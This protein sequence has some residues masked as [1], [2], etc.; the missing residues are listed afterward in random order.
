M[1]ADSLKEGGAV[2]RVEALEQEVARLKDEMQTLRRMQVRSA[3]D[4]PVFGDQVSYFPVCA[5]RMLVAEIAPDLG[6]WFWDVQS[7]TLDC[8]ERAHYLL[9]SPAGVLLTC[10]EVY[11]RIHPEDSEQLVARFA[12]LKANSKPR[13]AEFRVVLS[14]GSVRWLHA[15][16][17]GFSG[18]DGRVA[19]IAGVLVDVTKYKEINMA[20]EAANAELRESNHR[21]DLALRNA[22][23]LVYSTDSDLRYTWIY[24]PAGAFL[25][26]RFLGKRLEEIFPPEDVAELI[27]AK[28]T[29]IST[30]KG[31]W[32]EVKIRLGEEDKY[33]DISIEPLRGSDGKVNGLTAAAME[34]T[35]LRR[36]EDEIVQNVTRLEVQRRLLQHR[37]MERIRIAR[38]LHDGPIQE[39]LA[40]GFTLQSALASTGNLETIQIL[41]NMRVELQRLISDL[42]QV[43]NDLRPPTLGSFG[44]EK[45]IRSHAMAFRERHPEIQIHL[46]LEPESVRLDESARLALFRIYQESLNN[47][48]RHA[49]A[50]E[51]HIRLC[52]KPRSL[53]LQIQ[54]NG[55][56]FDFPENWVN[57]VRNGHFGLAGIHE[58]AETA[59]GEVQI[60]S[61][62][63]QGTCIT[64][65]IPI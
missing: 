54:D 27:E 25:P 22:P 46:D 30:G 18:A 31:L 28:Q 17:N 7:R 3:V 32:R 60:E 52:F 65:E 38:D 61:V 62:L 29:A 57:L 50:T 15:V 41:E 47:I 64:V 20:L 21:F 12:E 16:G 44:L 58:H 48:F 40:L 6:T 26:E 36:M 4:H 19:L 9:G 2:G 24:D 39:L 42:R 1:E 5:L 56:G 35:G 37:E 34:V 33:Y 8:D 10:Q 63:G 13:T 59:G 51:V 11:S 43:C 23:I 49:E 53:T 45:A 14:D 55:K